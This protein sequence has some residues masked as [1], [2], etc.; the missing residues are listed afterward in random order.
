MILNQVDMKTGALSE[1]IRDFDVFKIG[2]ASKFL[3]IGLSMNTFLNR[4]NYLGLIHSEPDP[5]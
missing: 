1:V 3:K 2:V 5:Q 4:D